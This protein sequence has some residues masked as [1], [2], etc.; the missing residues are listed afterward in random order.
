MT[1]H[2][3]EVKD[4]KW[5]MRAAVI[6]FKGLSGAHDGD[7][8]GRYSVG[9]LDH[10]GITSKTGSKVVLFFLLFSYYSYCLEQLYTATLDNTGN[11]NTT[12]KTIERIHNHRGLTWNSGEQQLPCLAH[13]VNLANV[14]V[15]THITK[16]AAVENATAIWEYDPTR[17]DNC[18]LG[19][20][21]DMIAAI[22]TLALKVRI[23][24]NCCSSLALSKSC[25]FKHL[26]NALNI[27]IAPRFVVDFPK[28]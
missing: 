14:A 1:A 3:I 15:M 26:V 25:R 17:D 22:R 12:C 19:G 8:L 18:V 16:I 10:V 7:N 11:N 20:S 6:G 2:W 13:V 24:Y 5:K 9:L 28:A 4:G 27:F 23:K 21:L